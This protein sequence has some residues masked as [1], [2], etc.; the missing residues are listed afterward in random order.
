MPLDR[1]PTAGLNYYRNRNLLI[2]GNFDLWQRGTS[3]SAFSGKNYLADRFYTQGTGS[4]VTPSQQSFGIQTT[5]PGNPRYFHR[6]VVTSS[7]GSSN[8]ALMA[9]PIENVTLTGGL[10]I[11]LSFWA[12]ADTN[13][14]IASEFI[15][16]FGSGGGSDVNSIGVTTYSLTNSWQKF[17]ATITVPAIVTTVSSSIQTSFNNLIFWFDAGS[18]LNTR[19]NS[20]GQQSG[21]FDIAQ[22]QVEVGNVAT[23]FE[24]MP[25]GATF[26]LAQRYYQ[27][28][29]VR[30]NGYVAGAGQTITTG[31]TFSPYMRATPTVSKV[32]EGLDSNTASTN[33]AAYDALGGYL[34]VVSTIAGYSGTSVTILADAEF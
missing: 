12:K 16:S 25:I 31:F 21:T 19:T 18:S 9:Q 4:T 7:A 22:V 10:S 28:V 17:Y 32:G 3:L 13:R 2:N 27:Q 11:T 30:H 26:S 14:S 15:Q 34:N 20:L 8:F 5:V 23:D 6:T 33:I 24:M 29:R 1:I